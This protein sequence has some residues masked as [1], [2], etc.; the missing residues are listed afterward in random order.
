MAPQRVLS[1]TQ[2]GY[3]REVVGIWPLPTRIRALGPMHVRAYRTPDKLYDVD[4]TQV[5]GSIQYAE[6]SR[7]VPVDDAFR[8]KRE[9][10]ADL[11]RV[12][13]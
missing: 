5:P 8:M 6:I 2:T 13:R 12:G 1:Q 4:V 9:M 11:S 3:L 7:K 10:E